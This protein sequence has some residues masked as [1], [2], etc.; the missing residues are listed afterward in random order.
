MKC[1]R[2]FA[3]LVAA[4]ALCACQTVETATPPT[5]A[6]APNPETVPGYKRPS[7]AEALAA[8]KGVLARSLKDPEAARFSELSR[9]TT[10]NARG[11]PTDVVCGLVNAKN[12][13]GAYIGTKPFVY[14]V[15]RKEAHMAGEGGGSNVMSEVETTIVRNFC[16][17]FPA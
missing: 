12:S 9:R 16:V 10:Q 13:F 2:A 5:L 1:V 8:A 6:A 3:T 17:G 14:F 4:L 7:D 15:A 11:E